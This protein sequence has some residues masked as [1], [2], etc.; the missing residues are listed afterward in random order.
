MISHLVDVWSYF[1]ETFI[2]NHPLPVARD[3]LPGVVMK[4]IEEKGKPL[5]LKSAE[6]L[7]LAQMGGYLFSKFRYI[8]LTSQHRSGD[9]KH[10]AVT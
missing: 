6:K 4:Y 10:M 1:W 3:T 5:T 8:K 9:P 2:R 7:G